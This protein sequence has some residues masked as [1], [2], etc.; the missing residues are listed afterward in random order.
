MVCSKPARAIL[1]TFNCVFWLF[2]IVLLVL[3]L[4]TKYDGSFGQVWQDL[5]ADQMIQSSD[6]NAAS[7]ILI[8]AGLFTIIVGGVGC[9][10]ALKKSRF[11]LTVYIFIILI[12]LVAKLIAI[13]MVM[14]FK[15]DFQT[16]F[17]GALTKAFNSNS[18][19]SQQAVDE[20][21]QLFKCCGVNGPADYESDPPATCYS[22]NSTAVAYQVGCADQIQ[23]Y[24][25][26]HLPIISAILFVMVLTELAAVIFSILICAKSQK[27]YEI[28]G[29]E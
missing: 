18:T 12:L 27:E 13:Y 11:L 14:A 10:G 1:I 5:K 19:V 9:L 29:A 21:Q 20:V 3:G 23:V 25:T 16:Q 22:S 2:G 26:N 4:M 6:L 7:W 8:A 24:V 17:R 15:D 28:F